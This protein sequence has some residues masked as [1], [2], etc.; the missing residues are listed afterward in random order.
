MVTSRRPRLSI[1]IPSYNVAPYIAECLD[2]IAS[3]IT[4]RCEI[5]VCDDFSTDGTVDAVLACDRFAGRLTLLQSDENRG[6]SHSRNR[7]VAAAQGDFLW[8]IDSDDKILD[9][10]IATILNA[11]DEQDPDIVFFD[12]RIWRPDPTPEQPAY[13]IQRRSFL[14]V[15]AA[16]CGDPEAAVVAAM[17]CGNLHPWSRVF[18]RGLFD[19]DMLFPEGKI[20]EDVEVVPLLISRAQSVFYIP[21]PFI[22]YRSRPGSILTGLALAR[23]AEIISALHSMRVRYEALHGAMSPQVA[24]ATTGFASRQLV[25]LIKKMA[26]SGLPGAEK[27]RVLTQ[28]LGQFSGVHRGGIWTVAVSCYRENGLS[29]AIRICKRLMQARLLI[30]TN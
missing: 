29:L 25:S 24:Q 18:R 7:L 28:A 8:F 21:Q 5:I 27:K 11:L 12:Y 14:G 4:D 30:Y 2:S 17:R 20:F 15:A 10:A 6:V 16:C 26:R 9:G 3:Q 1:L 23:T 22:A 13:G 19:G